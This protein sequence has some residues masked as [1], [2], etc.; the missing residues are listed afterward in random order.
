MLALRRTCAPHYTAVSDKVKA[1]LN[2]PQLI[3]I[4]SFCYSR[5]V[6]V[7]VCVFA[8]VC[9]CVCARAR[10]RVCETQRERER[11]RVV[12]VVAVVGRLPLLCS[13]CSVCSELRLNI[14]FLPKKTAALH[15]Y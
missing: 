4:P 14:I 11:E 12:V 2:P 9:V 1:V 3:S 15:T 10:A 6:C 7:C 13:V 8:C 5:S